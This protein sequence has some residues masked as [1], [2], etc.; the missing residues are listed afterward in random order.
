MTSLQRMIRARAVVVACL[1]S[2]TLT[3]ACTDKELKRAANGVKAIALSVETIK[4]ETI[5]A[6][7]DGRLTVEQAVPIMEFALKMNTA[8][9]TASK[10]VRELKTLQPTDR[11]R[12]NDV[13]QPVSVASAELRNSVA[14][15]QDA[16][17]RTTLTASLVA[18][19]TSVAAIRIILGNGATR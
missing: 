6:T 14:K 8:G 19:D 12:L 7:E 16:K 9:K 17:L 5:S 10:I 3:V 15:I 11:T 18:I 1:I 2:L 4:N 13:L